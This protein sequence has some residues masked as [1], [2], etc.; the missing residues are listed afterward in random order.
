MSNDIPHGEQGL[1]IH[2][3]YSS[4]HPLLLPLSLPFPLSLPSLPL[5]LNG[6]SYIVKKLKL[7]ILG[8]VKLMFMSQLCFMLPQ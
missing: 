8:L 5:K 4:K 1:N 7:L 2:G 6:H 3:Q